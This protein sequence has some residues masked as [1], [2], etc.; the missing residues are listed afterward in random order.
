MVKNIVN[1][2]IEKHTSHY[3][4]LQKLCLIEVNEIML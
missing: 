3:L 4:L 1:L 2:Q